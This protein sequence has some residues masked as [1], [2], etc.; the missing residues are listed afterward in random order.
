GKERSIGSLSAV[1]LS[2]WSLFLVAHGWSSSAIAMLTIAI[3][4]TIRAPLIIYHYVLV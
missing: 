3:L 2:C 1:L 4:P